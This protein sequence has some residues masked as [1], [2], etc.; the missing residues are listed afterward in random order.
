MDARAPP[1]GGCAQ[2]NDSWPEGY[3][4][5]LQRNGALLTDRLR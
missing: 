1:V 2:T 4:N 3:A 5:V